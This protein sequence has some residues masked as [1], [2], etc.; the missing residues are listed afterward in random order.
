MQGVVDIYSINYD[1]LPT[2]PYAAKVMW[3]QLSFPVKD[4]MKQ[5]KAKIISTNPGF[6]LPIGEM[7]VIDV[8]GTR[9]LLE[10]P[11]DL[12]EGQWGYAT[13]YFTSPACPDKNW[14]YGSGNPIGRLVYTKSYMW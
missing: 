9:V 5:T 6:K 7:T 12:Q 1:F 4:L 8:I 13:R 10:A 2:I 14:T 3:V 11:I